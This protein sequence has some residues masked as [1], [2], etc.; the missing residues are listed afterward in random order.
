MIFV[1]RLVGWDQFEVF[2]AVEPICNT[3]NATT[4]PNITFSGHIPYISW[5]ESV[6]GQD[7]MFIGHFEGGAQAP[8]FKLDTPDR[9]LRT[10][11][12]L[13]VDTRSPIS[14]TC[15]ATPFSAD[16]TTCRGGAL[17]TPFA[18]LTE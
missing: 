13:R 8:G 6:A 18:L 7:R 17:G 11:D 3:I 12:G 2:N 14:S 5:H 15:T 16:G 4:R 9:L 1:S 10:P